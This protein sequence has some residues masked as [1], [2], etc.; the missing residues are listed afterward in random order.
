MA[1][2]ISFFYKNVRIIC[3]H[4]EDHAGA[5]FDGT[6]ASAERDYEDE[7]PDDDEQRRRGEVARI[8]EV[9]KVIVDSI[10]S[11]TDRYY[12]RTGQL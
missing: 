2:T 8:Q 7:S 5:L 1:S 9:R 4:H 6:T 12:H 11:R 10:D 3:T